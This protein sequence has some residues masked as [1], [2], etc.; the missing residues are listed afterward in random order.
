MLFDQYTSVV[1]SPRQIGDFLLR[2][3]ARRRRSGTVAGPV[4]VEPP[5]RAVPIP[6]EAPPVLVDQPVVE[7]AHQDQVVQVG[8]APVLPPKDVT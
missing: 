4:G 5:D 1:K 7:C 6:L 3:P 2:G 8:P